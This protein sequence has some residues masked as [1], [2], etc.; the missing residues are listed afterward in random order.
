MPTRKSWVAVLA[1]TLILGACVPLVALAR[2]RAPQ[3]PTPPAA[4]SEMSAPVPPT[5][6]AAMTAP[7][8][9]T[10]RVPRVPVPPIPPDEL[11]AVGPP[12]PEEAFEWFGD[13]DHEA[14][15]MAGP[16]DFE[17]DELAFA[18][19]EGDVFLGDGHESATV[20]HGFGLRPRGARHRELMEAVKL[21]DA[22]RERLRD[23]HDRQRRDAIRARADLRIAMLD[24][25]RMLREDRVDRAEIESQLDKIAAERGAMRKARVMAGLEAREVLT[26]QQRAQLKI[27]REKFRDDVR[28]RVRERLRD[29]GVDR[30]TVRIRRPHSLMDD[31]Q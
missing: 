31:S 22:Q 8:P 4:P 20:E 24:L 7:T 10:P 26:A 25:R 23:M 16:P 19:G 1:I 13:V 6:A 11:D 3:P 9:R 29:R 17:G 28:I 15:E 14:L 27:A 5:P 12:D 2:A 18:P 30:R 21:S